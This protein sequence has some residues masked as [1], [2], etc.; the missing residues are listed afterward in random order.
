MG[1]GSRVSSTSS[2]VVRAQARAEAIAAVKKA[3]M[4]KNRSAPVAQSTIVIEK[5]K[6]RMDRN[7][8]I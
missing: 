1:L 8:F 3:E 4:Q 7:S 5:E 6:A 2:A